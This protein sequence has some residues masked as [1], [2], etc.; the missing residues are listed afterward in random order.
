MADL[1]AVLAAWAVRKADPE[2][3]STLLECVSV[4]SLQAWKDPE[5]L[6]LLHIACSVPNEFRCAEVLLQAG[7]DPNVS[8]LEQQP[9]FPEDHEHCWSPLCFA[10]EHSAFLVSLLLTA[11]ADVGYKAAHGWTALHGAC[12]A[13]VAPLV[14]AGA[15]VDSLC[16]LD[17]SMPSS[18]LQQAATRGDAA[19]CRALL[20]HGADPNGLGAQQVNWPAGDPFETPLHG[21]VDSGDVATVEVLLAAPGIRVDALWD[22]YSPLH[23]AV[24]RSPFML[25]G[26]AVSIVQ[27]LLT[28]GASIMVREGRSMLHVAAEGANWGNS[29]V[30]QALL[31]PHVGCVAVLDSVCQDTDSTALMDAAAQGDATAVRLLLEAGADVAKRSRDRSTALHAAS[32][33]AVAQLLLDAAGPSSLSWQDE[34]QRTPLHTARSADV[35][36]LLLAKGA[37]ARA[38]DRQGCIPLHV[39]AAEGAAVGVIELLLQAYPGS[40]RAVVDLGGQTALH[41][42]ASGACKYDAADAAFMAT[43]LL[44]QHGADVNAMDAQGRTPLVVMLSSRLIHPRSLLSLLMAGADLC[45]PLPGSPGVLAW[46]LI[47]DHCPVV[48]RQVLD[49][50]PSEQLDVDRLLAAARRASTRCAATYVLLFRAACAIDADRAAR[51]HAMV[52]LPGEE[53]ADLPP[54]MLQLIVASSTAWAM[55]EEAVQRQQAEVQQAQQLFIAAALHMR[56]GA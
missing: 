43:Q 13:A 30:W 31:Q 37:D 44:L 20:Q 46:Q 35:V 48:A 39:A 12:A 11:G 56:G 23:M 53:V 9:E 17:W 10:A 8:A 7:F 47:G 51:M 5:Q 32:S 38:V 22:G 3:L 33:G 42:A 4:D 40:S 27:M 49:R 19:C 45:V 6:S 14:A 1:V 41:A 29:A 50:L 34:Q 2:F 52:M 24:I 55:A 15:G 36:E 54:A 26:N 28:A 16:H 25:P 18:A 21:A